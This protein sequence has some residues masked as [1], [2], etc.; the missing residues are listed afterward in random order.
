MLK[1]NREYLR[2]IEMGRYAA[3]CIDKG[4]AFEESL[5]MERAEALKLF[6]RHQPRMD[7]TNVDL[8]PWQKDLMCILEEKLDNRKVFWINGNKGN[9]GKSWMQCYI[10]SYY[11]RA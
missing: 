2:K 4:V 9:E 3:T 8:R 1:D 6:K 11:G 5:S 7:I 10:E